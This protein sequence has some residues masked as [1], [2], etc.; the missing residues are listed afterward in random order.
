MELRV[1]R[2]FLEVARERSVTRAAQTLHVSQPTLSKQLKDLER[3]LG[4]QL[5]RRSNYGVNLTEEGVL[6]R[7]RAEEIV[8]M[9]EKTEGEFRSLSGELGGDVR[10]GCAE[11]EDLRHVIRCI[12]AVQDAHPQVRFH[13]TSGNGEDLAERLEGGT[14]DFAVLAHPV[15]PTRFNV[16]ELPG[17]DTWGVIMR[18][19]SHLAALEKITPDDLAGMPLIISRQAMDDTH[20]RWFGDLADGLNIVAT[21]NLVFNAALMVREGVGYAISFDRLA[22]TGP[23]SGLAFRP[24]DPPITT[25]LHVVWKKYQVFTPATQL[26]LDEMRA[27]FG[28]V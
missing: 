4:H 14:F 25:K 2:Y 3:E 21:Y 16:L 1:L 11:S 8:D 10:I 12:K 13:L 27:R 9:V 19:D 20:A 15:D 24:L 23:G 17:H 22:Q 18:E 7:R 26:L 6:L 28:E 5:F